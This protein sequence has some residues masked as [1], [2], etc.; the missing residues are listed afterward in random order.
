MSTRR[1]TW[2]LLICITVVI[3]FSG[4]GSYFYERQQL[5]RYLAD[6]NFHAYEYLKTDDATLAL[7]TNEDETLLGLADMSVDGY[8]YGTVEILDMSPFDY[9]Y[10][11]D[12]SNNYIGIRL[13]KQPQNV[14]YLRII[15]E[16]IQEQHVLNRPEEDDYAA[17]H[18]IEL[19]NRPTSDWTLQTLD[20]NEQVIDS[21]DF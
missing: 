8:G 1:L 17:T 11:S 6:N 20:Q 19:R 7:F 16:R 12:D 21:I 5:K 13:N 4:I 10:S 3:V 15:G 14:A 2:A 18:I 9:I